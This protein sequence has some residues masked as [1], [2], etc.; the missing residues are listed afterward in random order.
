MILMQATKKRTT[1][2]SHVRSK[3]TTYYKLKMEQIL[4]EQTLRTM[5]EAVQP[6]VLNPLLADRHEPS[7]RYS[8]FKIYPSADAVSSLSGVPI[9]AIQLSMGQTNKSHA[10]KQMTSNVLQSCPANWN[11]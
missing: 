2:D 3:S 11:R 10:G 7:K 8:D 6:L 9:S 1:H 5:M 4:Q